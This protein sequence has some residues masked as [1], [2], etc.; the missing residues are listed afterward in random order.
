MAI[1]KFFGRSLNDM[2]EISVQMKGIANNHHH[3]HNNYFTLSSDMSRGYDVM[4]FKVL[5][6][7]FNFENSSFE[8]RPRWTENPNP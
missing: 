3:R 2:Y 7:I 1:T 4:I 6:E 8:S 5:E